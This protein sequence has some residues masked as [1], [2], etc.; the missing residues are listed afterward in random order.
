[1][2]EMLDFLEE[3]GIKFVLKAEQKKAIVNEQ[4]LLKKRIF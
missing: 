3:N 2:E 4:M 1:M